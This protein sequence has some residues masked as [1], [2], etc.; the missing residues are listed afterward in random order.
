MA[1]LHQLTP[2]QR[3]GEALA[4]R[5]M[6]INASST[7]MPLVFGAAGAAVG[8]GVMFWLVGGAVGAG[9]WAARRLAAHAIRSG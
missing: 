3:H 8:A 4:F 2:A 5:S 9:A 6:A 1:T 7:V